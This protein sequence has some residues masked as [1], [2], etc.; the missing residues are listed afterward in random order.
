MAKDE[1]ADEGQAAEMGRRRMEGRGRGSRQLQRASPHVVLRHTGHQGTMT[2]CVGPPFGQSLALT[3]HESQLTGTPAP[4][5]RA[6]GS[7][8]LEE[9]AGQ[10]HQRPGPEARVGGQDRLPE[11]AP[12]HRRRPA[13][14]ESSNGPHPEV[15]EGQPEDTTDA[16][17][18][19][20]C[21]LTAKGQSRLALCPM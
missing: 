18:V 3:S 7:A 17:D 11:W 15:N 5:V 2:V 13:T 4:V 8:R 12:A 9:A 14:V 19:S 21:G 6:P 10:R 16:R 20:L 1:A